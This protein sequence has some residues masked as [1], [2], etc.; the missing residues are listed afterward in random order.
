MQMHFLIAKLYFSL[1]CQ[2]KSERREDLGQTQEKHMMKVAHEVRN[3]S[4]SVKILRL[5]SKQD[6][7]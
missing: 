1:S 2:A 3:L 7:M 4:T 6:Q 5:K